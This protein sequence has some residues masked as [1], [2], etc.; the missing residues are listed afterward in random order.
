MLS[1]SSLNMTYG[2]VIH[3]LRGVDLTVDAGSIVALLGSNGAG[4]TSL[5]RAISGNL[6]AYRASISGGITLEGE[7]LTGL[8]PSEVVRRGLVQ[9]PE[10]RRIFQRMTVQENLAV[11]GALVGRRARATAE[12]EVYEL[13]PILAERRRQAAGLM[14]G[15]EQ[16]MLAIGRAMMSAPRMLMLDEPSLGLA[17]KMIA[18]I[19]GVIR[20]INAAGTT[21]LVIEQNANLALSLAGHASVLELGRVALSGPTSDVTLMEDVRRLYLASASEP[22][23]AGAGDTARKLSAK[24]TLL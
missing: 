9:V 2:R 19:E 8:S 13:F 4:K 5:L 6:S 11:G 24:E 20:Q 23:R 17:P 21:V 22:A 10:G 7:S 15:G 1:V 3:A 12:R 16:Q 14:S 18:V